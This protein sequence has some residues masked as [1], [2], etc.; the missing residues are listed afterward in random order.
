MRV[1]RVIRNVLLGCLFLLPLAANAQ[2]STLQPFTLSGKAYVQERGAA[3]RRPMFS[4]WVPRISV[5]VETNSNFGAELTATTDEAA[6]EVVFSGQVARD[7]QGTLLDYRFSAWNSFYVGSTGNLAWLRYQKGKQFAAA[8]PGFK[9]PATGNLTRNLALDDLCSLTVHLEGNGF[10]ADDYSYVRATA[11][12]YGISDVKDERS[13]YAEAGFSNKVTSGDPK[14]LSAFVISTVGGKARATVEMLVRPG[15]T[16]TVSGV[17]QFKDK[18]NQTVAVE[19]TTTVVVNDANCNSATATLPVRKPNEYVDADFLLRPDPAFPLSPAVKYYW[20]TTTGSTQPGDVSTTINTLENASPPAALH[21]H[22]PAEAGRYAASRVIIGL[23]NADGS[24]AQLTVPGNKFHWSPVATAATKKGTYPDSSFVVSQDETETLGFEADMAFLRGRAEVIGCAELSDLSKDLTRAEM[25]GVRPEPT[26]YFTDELGQSRQV[27][28]PTTNASSQ[29]PIDVLTGD[30]EMVGVPGPWRESQTALVVQ[31]PGVGPLLDGFVDSAITYSRINAPTFTL[32]AGKANAVTQTHQLGIGKA[33]VRMRV[34][35]EDGSSRPFRAPELRTTAMQVDAFGLPGTQFAFANV[36]AKGVDALRPEHQ[37]V[38]IAPPGKG[39]F[40][41]TAMVP[42]NPDGSGSVNK[43]TFP[44]MNDIPFRVPRADGSCAAT[45]AVQEIQSNGTIN[46]A[47]Y[48]DDERPPQANPTPVGT[49]AGGKID[50][51]VC[52]SS[53]VLTGTLSDESPVD[54]SINGYK[55]TVSG[56]PPSQSYSVDVPLP[57]RVNTVSAELTDRC[58][59]S[60]GFSYKIYRNCGPEITVPGTQTIF[61]GDPLDFTV[62]GTD[63]DGDDLLFSGVAIDENG[64]ETDISSV[65]DAVTGVVSITGAQTQPLEPGPYKLRFTVREVLTMVGAPPGLTDTKDVIIVV[66]PPNKP[67]VITVPGTITVTEGD[68]VNFTVT[69]ADPENETIIFSKLAGDEGSIDA[70]TGDFEIAVGVLQPGTYTVTFTATDPWGASDTKTTT[71]V[72]TKRNGPP[73]I[74]N[75]G[76]VTVP[77]GA[78]ATLT[79]TA[80]DPDG[81]ALTYSTSG[82]GSIDP[83]TGVYTL[84]SDTPPGSYIVTF[85]VSD[86]EFAD[87]VSVTITVTPVNQPPVIVVPD[88][89]TIDEGDGLTFTVTA[90]DPDGDTL[91]FSTSG[92]G[93]IDPATGVYTLPADTPPGRYEVTFTVTDGQLTDSKK[94][95]ITV[96]EKGAPKPNHPPEFEAVD[97]I[98]T[99]GPDGFTV[100]VTDPDGDTLTCKADKL[101][102]GAKFDPQTLTVSWDAITPAGTYTAEITCSDGNLS[103]TLVVNIRAR[104]FDRVGGGWAGCSSTSGAGAFAL[105]VVLLGSFARRRRVA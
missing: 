55:A 9:A 20:F 17:V 84:P 22:L 81:D 52:G 69:A 12:S 93:T 102:P 58:G 35:N 40:T 11:L 103:S 48:D 76:D 86:G 88:A 43:S 18:P 104:V 63:P 78:G 45:C 13:V 27:L 91:T 53:V 95:V 44:A 10:A 71:I 99:D 4:G 73:V 59:G 90:T 23:T 94:V 65:I 34:L 96:V 72:V 83:T 75:P 97:D 31:R 26:E 70:A 105:L 16:Y 100:V 46:W 25:Q 5:Q 38:I 62:S 47:Y 8:H 74:A 68:A 39:T 14:D 49:P 37:V 79:V 50:R 85:T 36:T 57:D 54:I 1:I 6:R 67:P 101:P 24:S 3:Q 56:T 89:T 80:T 61:P 82:P 28:G 64:N 19:S 66:R 60:N 41:P 29:T 77:D 87:S 2:E 7:H 42:A 51:M 15:L 98:E 21:M 32:V 92:P 30:Y 33:T